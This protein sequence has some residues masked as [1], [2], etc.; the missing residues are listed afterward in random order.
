MKNFPLKTLAT[1]KKGRISEENKDGLPLLDM[2]YLRNADIEP[3]LVGIT[4]AVIS[5]TTDMLILWDGSNSGEFIESKY[6]VVGSTLALIK[7]N[8]QKVNP[9]FFY[10]ACKAN[11]KKLQD[12]TIGMGI[13]HVNGEILESL[14]ISI[15][16]MDIQ[17][18]IAKFLDHKIA[19]IDE[20]IAKKKQLI[21]L[22]EEKRSLTISQAV[23]GHKNKKKLKRIIR[24]IIVKKALS[25]NIYML[26][27][28][29]SWTG[30]I[31]GRTEAID[32]SG[33]LISFEKGDI[34]FGKLRPYLAKVMKAEEAGS[35]SGEF[36]VLRT[37]KE[38]ES[39]YLFYKLI[40]KDFIDQ[41]NS[42]TYGT[43]MPRASWDIIGN[44]SIDL[45]TIREQIEMIIKFDGISKQVEKVT[46]KI[47]DSIHLLEEYKVSLISN[48][49]TG[50]VKV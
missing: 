16:D 44:M 5:S 10:Y 33:E 1:I 3:K 15:P 43:K 34:L 22:L 6:G 49:V 37:S 18:M 12:L 17:I 29:E 11:E 40:S 13:P 7:P 46:N 8:I 48:A 9:R 42:A 45:P 41:V 26:E 20:A 38:I 32:V 50:R 4:N 35:C 25:E 30:K 14:P 31:I 27:N 39:K 21:N 47:K 28:I 19:K 36:L 23:N 2:E 24:N